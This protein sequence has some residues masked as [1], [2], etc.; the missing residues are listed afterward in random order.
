MDRQ[1]GKATVLGCAYESYR[2]PL[3]GQAPKQLDWETEALCRVSSLR[4][5]WSSQPSHAVGTV[6]TCCHP[7]S[8]READCRVSRVLRLPETPSHRLTGDSAVF[9]LWLRAA[10]WDGSGA[11]LVGALLQV[12]QGRAL[13]LSILRL[14]GGSVGQPGRSSSDHLFPRAPPSAAFLASPE[15]RASLRVRAG[16]GSRGFC[17]AGLGSGPR[18]AFPGARL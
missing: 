11:R 4:P 15:A 17:L 2:E 13:P 3:R 12:Q 18:V 6:G 16:R 1:S 10:R 14:S 8:V 5:T 7:E 9:V